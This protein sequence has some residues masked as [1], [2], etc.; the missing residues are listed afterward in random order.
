[1]NL[2]VPLFLTATLQENLSQLVLGL[3]AAR[4]TGYSE[5]LTKADRSY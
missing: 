3:G 5:L 2:N 1:M 4:R